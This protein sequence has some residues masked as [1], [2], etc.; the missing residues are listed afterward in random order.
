MKHV[1]CSNGFCSYPRFRKRDIFWDILGQVMA[2]H[3]HIQMFVKRVSCVW[4][5]RI[6]TGGQNVRMSD[7]CDDIRSMT[8]PGPFRVVCAELLATYLKNS[9]NCTTLRTH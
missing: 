6:G 2:N 4:S 1:L 5:R 8:S 9:L 3:Q 7:H